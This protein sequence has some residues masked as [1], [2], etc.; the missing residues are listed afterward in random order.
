MRT[1][2]RSLVAAGVLLT[3]ALTAS[4]PAQAAWTKLAPTTSPSSRN[5]HVMCTDTN[6]NVTVLFGSLNN[7]ETWEYDG[8]NWKKMTPSVSPPGLGYA[9]FS[10]DSARKVCVLFGGRVSGGTNL[11][12]E[13]DGTNWKQIKTTN[14]PATRYGHGQCYDTRRQ[15][16]VVFSG[17]G[18]NPYHADTWEYD[19]KDWKQVATTGPIGRIYPYM[20]YDFLRGKCVLFSGYASGAQPSVDIQD[21]WEWDGKTWTEIKLACQP[22]ARWGHSMQYVLPRGIVMFGGNKQTAPN[23]GAKQDT[24]LYNG[25]SWS[26]IKPTGAPSARRSHTL[27][28]DPGTNKALLFGGT[29]GGGETHS[30]D[31]KNFAPA[32]YE[33]Y[34]A[35]C[36][37]SNGI[38]AL[39]ALNC[40]PPFINETFTAQVTNIPGAA[41]VY[42]IFG[43]S[44][45]TWNSNKLP[46]DWSVYGFTG[47]SLHASLDF[48]LTMTTNGNTASFAAKVPNNSSVV[49]ATFYNQAFVFDS[50]ANASGATLSNGAAGFVGRR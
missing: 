29:T 5:N 34:G 36:K 44:N 30:L 16:T 19:G 10:Y 31:L 33:P 12:W 15:V 22:P 4:L 20:E 17:I 35:G 27:A 43:A 7:T 8:K 41:K 49:G 37:G 26:E 3:A 1:Y 6:R 42:L 13:W 18:G 32:G 28:G 25:T 14:S 47:C 46:M 24:W 40:N 45:T 11:T 9:G 48:F 50:T 39:G 38:P 2:H 23:N 21:T